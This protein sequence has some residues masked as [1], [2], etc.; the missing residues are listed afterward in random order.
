[1]T[2]GNMMGFDTWVSADTGATLDIMTNLGNL[3]LALDQIGIEPTVMDA[4]G[5][6][7]E[8]RV[9]RLPDAPLPREITLSETVNIRDTGDTPLW[10]CATFEDGNQAWTSPI[11]LFR[12]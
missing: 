7:R 5:L 6:A 12:D 8:L 2:T 4:G 1:M 3:S 9:Q 11:Y 10:I